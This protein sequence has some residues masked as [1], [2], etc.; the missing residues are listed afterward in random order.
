MTTARTCSMSGYMDGPWHCST[1]ACPKDE[2]C[3]A[4]RRNEAEAAFLARHEVD[5]AWLAHYGLPLVTAR[6]AR[7]FYSMP[8]LD[9]SKV[10]RP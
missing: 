9:F 8:F 3:G 7:S 5:N 6:D 4:T 10:A 1:H 2:T